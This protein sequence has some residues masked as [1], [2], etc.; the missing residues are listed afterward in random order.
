MHVVKKPLAAF[1]PINSPSA[2]NGPDTNYLTLFLAIDFA[3]R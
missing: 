2:A 3:A 1:G